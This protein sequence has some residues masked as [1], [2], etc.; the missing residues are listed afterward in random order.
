MNISETKCNADG[1]AVVDTDR[2]QAVLDDL[3]RLSRQGGGK[4]EF[5]FVLR[6]GIPA[7]TPWLYDRHHP[8]YRRRVEDLSHFGQ[9]RPLGDLVDM[10]F[11]FRPSD[12]VNLLLPGRESKKGIPVIEGRDIGRRSLNRDE[13]RYRILPEQSEAF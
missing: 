8:D 11:G 12:Q 5:G 6:E 2:Q 9:V 10:W 7:G 3:T 4:R 13:A 1:R